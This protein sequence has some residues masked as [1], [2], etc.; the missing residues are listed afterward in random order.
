MNAILMILFVKITLLN[1]DFRNEV[2]YLMFHNSIDDLEKALANRSLLFI[3]IFR[4]KF[5]FYKQSYASKLFYKTPINSYD[6][7]VTYLSSKYPF[8]KNIKY[9]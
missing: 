6:W 3:G 9:I 5:R 7:L 4:S 8:I 2:S 1:L